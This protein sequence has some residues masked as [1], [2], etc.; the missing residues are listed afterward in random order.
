MS[1]LAKNNA[2]KETLLQTRLRRENQVCKVILV[3]V[4]DNKLNHAQREDVFMMFT[5]SKWVKNDMLSRSREG[6]D[7]F[8]MDYKDFKTVTHL[9][10]DRNPIVTTLSHLPSQMLQSVVESVK[11]DI[12]S[13]SKAKAKGQKVGELKFVSEYTSIDLKQKD[14]TYKI[15][16]KNK[17]KIQGIKKPLKVNGMDQFDAF[18]Q[19]EFANAK[20]L[21]RGGD[22]Y[23]AF[24]VFVPKEEPKPKDL[25]EIGVDFGCETSLTLSDGRKIN[26]LAEEDESLK[27]LQRRINRCKKGS[28]NRYKLRIMLRKKYLHLSNKKDD[29]ARKA[30]SLLSRYKV[31]MQD[32]QLRA[33]KRRHGKKVQHGILGRVKELLMRDAETV[34]LNRF[35]PTSKMCV[36]CGYKHDGLKVW[37]R[38]FMCPMCGDSEDRDVHAAK[39][40]IWFS[41]NII[42][43]GRTEYTPADFNERLREFFGGL[44]QE[45]A[46]C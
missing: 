13:L 44:K 18:P 9:D 43:V 21:L 8:S 32:E 36:N 34:V 7:I 6:E 35:I 2:I 19:C 28:S 20:L 11:Q 14:V 40:M 23:I 39:N 3:K 38:T 27:K 24:T 30:V 12:R 15:V 37:D 5:E 33:W 17:V 29:A 26:C 16:G 25:G 41:K 42:G 22:C 45:A 46:N 4:Q 1:N 10:K 31:Y